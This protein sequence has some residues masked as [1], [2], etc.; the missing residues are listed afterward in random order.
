M[1]T[2]PMLALKAWAVWPETTASTWGPKRPGDDESAAMA[3]LDKPG[4]ALEVSERLKVAARGQDTPPSSLG[5]GAR[6]GIRAGT[7][8]L[9]V[10]LA[11]QVD[12][13]EVATDGIVYDSV[14]LFEDLGGGPGRWGPRPR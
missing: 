6:W 7:W 1:K 3:A 12:S 4:M 10:A 11:A 9:E 13:R 8:T 14:R 5:Q 2:S